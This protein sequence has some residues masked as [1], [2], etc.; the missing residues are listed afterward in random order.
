MIRR[1]YLIL[2]FV[3]VAGFVF[4]G[5]PIYMRINQAGFLP[6][7]K[8]TAVVFSNEDLADSNFY[9]ND[10]LTGDRKF[11]PVKPGENFGMFGNFAYNYTLDFSGLR[12]EGKYVIKAP[13]KTFSYAFVISKEAGKGISE[14]VLNFFRAQ[15]C[16]DNLFLQA[17]C[18]LF[19]GTSRLDGK[20]KGGPNN[21]KI[22]DA[23]GGW[24]DAGDYIKFMI[25]EAGSTYMLLFA[26]KENPK[27]F[28]DEYLATGAPGSNKIPD[29]LDEAKIGLDWI[30][31]MHPAPEEFYYQ[32]GDNNDHEFGWRLPSKDTTPYDTAPY[33]PVYFGAGGNTCGKAAAA[34]ALAYKIWAYDLADVKYGQQCL[35]HA[36][37]LYRLGLANLKAIKS[38]PSDFY[39]E[40]SFYDDMELAAAELFKATGKKEYL[41]QAEDFALKTGS[42]YGW[43]DW[44]TFNFIAHYELYPNAINKSELLEYM[45]QDI[46]VDEKRAKLDAFGMC[47]EYV[48]GSMAGL[49]GAILRGKLYEK[50]T[51]DDSF[52]DIYTGAYDYLMGKNQW[53]VC[54]IVGIG[55]NYPKYPHGQIAE[56]SGK[57][58]IGMPIEGPASE[59]T[60]NDMNITL[61]GND[62]YADFNSAKCVYHDD[63]SDYVTNE[64]TIWQAAVSV[65]AFSEMQ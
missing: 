48:W 7:T 19:K 52:K 56:F 44:G 34:F 42:G 47:A 21:G 16:G 11:G 18:H 41:K 29:V 5:A 62:R 12:N 32:V 35:K 50:L 58:I 59:Q 2:C 31:K 22:M 33:R 26:Y 13:D 1:L 43:F 51:G 63:R 17:P 64:M 60:F 55:E 4:G 37:D 57:E 38:M 6:D 10:A 24:H 45:K 40:Q 61:S 39:G 20:I 9:I 46:L 3:W 15:R 54:F 27:K 65:A 25:G 28:V 36:E 53:G 30:M 23:S 49:T 14:K 8:K